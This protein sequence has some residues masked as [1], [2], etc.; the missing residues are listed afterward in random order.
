MEN[1]F[2]EILGMSFD[3]AV[4]VVVVVLTR[5][6]I[7]KAPKYFCKILWGLVGLRFCIPFSLKSALSLMPEQ[8]P[9]AVSRVASQVM[10]TPVEQGISF[11]EVLSVVW[12][13]VGALLLTY[14]FLSYFKLKLKILDSVLLKDNIYQSERIDSPF[15]CGFIK[16]KIY[17]PYGLEKETMECVLQHEKNHIKN[18]DHI[19]KYLGFAVLCVHWFNPLAWVSYF[20][21]CKD[22]ELSCDESVVKHYDADGCRSYAKALLELGVNKVKLSACPVAF[23]EVS[24]KTRIKSVI[25]Y[26]KAGKVLVL[27]SL[28]LCAVVAVCFMTEPVVK[29]K[30][31]EKRPEKIVSEETNEPA[32]EKVT[33]PTTEAVTEPTTEPFT[34]PATESVE[35]VYEVVEEP[36]VDYEELNSIIESQKVRLREEAI[37]RN[38]IIMSEANENSQNDFVF[39]HGGHMS[40]DLVPTGNTNSVELPTVSFPAD[41]TPTHNYGN[42]NY[43]HFEGNQ[44][45][46]N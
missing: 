29:A 28:C 12:L 42:T 24:I 15:V 23:G 6:L 20:L 37:R 41:P 34:E 31:I 30:D 35:E 43:P 5:A 21:L 17:L 3:A 46:Y 38:E 40:A 22:I 1:L 19:L 8:D 11:I 26:R 36:T 14:G 13:G 16:P 18:G 27:L 2:N 10:A 9:E 4:I 45:V 25:K 7:Y 44:W 39:Y 32:T 33:E